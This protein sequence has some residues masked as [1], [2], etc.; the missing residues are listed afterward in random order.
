MAA[1]DND[2]YQI[3]TDAS[4]TGGHDDDH[5]FP[6][7]D[8]DIRSTFQ[9]HPRWTS[10]PRQSF[11]SSTPSSLLPPTAVSADMTTA[12]ALVPHNAATFSA[13]A[14]AA[15]CWTAPNHLMPTYI[16]ADRSTASTLVDP[17]AIS[18]HWYNYFCALQSSTP[19]TATSAYF[20]S[21]VNLMAANMASMTTGP[22]D[23]DTLRRHPTVEVDRRQHSDD[24]VI[25]NK[26]DGDEDAIQSARRCWLDDNI[27][28]NRIAS[29]PMI[30]AEKVSSGVV[31]GDR[32]R[33]RKQF[34]PQQQHQQQ[35]RRHRSQHSDDE[36]GDESDDA[37]WNVD[38]VESVENNCDFR[39]N[40]DNAASPTLPDVVD[41][42]TNRRPPVVD[43]SAAD[44]LSLAEQIQTG[45]DT[46]QRNVAAMTG[47]VTSPVVRPDSRHNQLMTSSLSASTPAPSMIDPAGDADR[48]TWTSLKSN[49]M[50]RRLSP[51]DQVCSAQP[52]RGTST[53]SP[54]A[55]A[56]NARSSS[57]NLRDFSDVFLDDDEL[58]RLA[59]MLKEEI[60][61]R[62]DH[63]V[64]KA[65]EMCAASNRRQLDDANR[66]Q[67]R[68]VVD[69][70]S[71]PLPVSGPVDVDCQTAQLQGR[72]TSELSAPFAAY[73]YHHQRQQQQHQ[74][75]GMM[76]PG[77]NEFVHRMT[78]SRPRPSV[79]SEQTEALPLLTA[80]SDDAAARL[81]EVGSKKK[82]KRMKV[83]YVA[84]FTRRFAICFSNVFLILFK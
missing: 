71:N 42:S 79:W 61:G 50:S 46:I 9:Q 35:R 44:E 20:R 17:H 19:T 84:R 76:M 56:T 67:Q 21:V 29:T 43:V 45:I 65:I 5:V 10:T 60:V 27:V 59:A 6:P 23:S 32:K 82:K 16:D 30:S 58:R 68:P 83:S 12:S 52:A 34:W 49:P 33:K 48:L 14:A 62:V 4:S 28:S 36:D 69:A 66:K 11:V 54:G 22:H 78:F 26:V 2:E 13:P 15:T 75:R 55:G 64:D 39:V 25:S 41:H 51:C 8:A 81:S 18:R 1:T 40:T 7:D 80:G 74:L 3:H 47:H 73:Y 63:I 53:Y 77:I 37:V 38:D 72:M 57:V 31:G 24:D 70:G